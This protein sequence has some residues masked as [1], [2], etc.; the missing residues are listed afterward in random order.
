MPRNLEIKARCADLVAAAER[1]VALGAVS[2]GVLRQVDTYF[3]C[4]QGRLKLRETEGAP[5]ELIA[6]HRPDR[7]D[8]RASDYSTAQVPDAAAL[9]VVLATSLGVRAVVAKVRRLYLFRQ[10]RIHLDE[11]ERLGQFAELETA[12][13]GRADHE[14]GAELAFIQ[15][16]LAIAANDLLAGSYADL[17]LGEG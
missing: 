7:A 10:T 15:E 17:L 8:A 16:A 1:A 3:H 12:A 11:V 14:V 2:A 6:Y 5:A 13:Q 4:R 9:K